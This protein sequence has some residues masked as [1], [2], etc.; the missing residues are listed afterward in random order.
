M[1]ALFKFAFKQPRF[2]NFNKFYFSD[3]KSVQNPAENKVH[4]FVNFHDKTPKQLEE[5][6]RNAESEIFYNYGSKK[7]A[8]G[9][10][11][12][13]KT[14]FLAK[15]LRHGWF[16][17]GDLYHSHKHVIPVKRLR[18]KADTMFGLLKQGDIAC[19]LEG[20]EEFDEIHFVLDKKYTK[21]L[22]S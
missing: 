2:I 17:L 13:N 8:L 1:N 22:D 14:E 12:F 5:F 9:S 16:K 19:V 11:M 18:T 3:K 15:K 7:R 6:K 10:Q 21:H 20:R 4:E